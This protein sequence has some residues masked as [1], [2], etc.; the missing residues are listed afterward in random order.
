MAAT[1]PGGCFAVSHPGRASVFS[2]GENGM[3]KELVLPPF[4]VEDRRFGILSRYYEAV[5]ARL[6]RRTGIRR[7]QRLTISRHSPGEVAGQV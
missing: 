5:S 7:C 6:S 1:F 2:R 3:G 4:G